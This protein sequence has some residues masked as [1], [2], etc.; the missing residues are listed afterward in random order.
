MKAR[1]QKESIDIVTVCQIVRR[2]LA[3]CSLMV[4]V[5]I[6]LAEKV[7]PT[8]NGHLPVRMPRQDQRPAPLAVVVNPALRHNFP[9]ACHSGTERKLVGHAALHKSR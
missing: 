4:S 9:K 1:V 2:D 3:Q 8:I 7:Q 5:P 6:V